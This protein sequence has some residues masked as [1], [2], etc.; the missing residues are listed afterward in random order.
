MRLWRSLRIVYGMV[1][2]PWVVFG[3]FNTILNADEKKG[4][5]PH[6]L[7]KS[8]N[9]I[10]CMNDCGLMYL[11]LMEEQYEIN[12][13]DHNRI[14]RH[15]SQA[16]YIKWLKLQDSIV[17]QKARVKWADRR[18]LDNTDQISQ[19]AIDQFTNILTR[20][21]DAGDSSGSFLRCLDTFVT[22]ID[23]DSL[24]AIPAKEEI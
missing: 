18:K 8:F 5:V 10:S 6:T 17:R 20:S 19:A 14:L 11:G 23:N 7:S 15:K 21:N 16:D 12:N 1:N 24:E 4:G 3:D 22:D 9:F 13:S 2:G